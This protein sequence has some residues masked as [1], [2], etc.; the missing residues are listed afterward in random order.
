M[1]PAL[2]VMLCDDAGERFFGEGPCR[3]LHLIEETGS[4][5]SAAAQM[6]LSYS[7]ALAI[8]KRAEAERDGAASA[9]S[10]AGTVRAQRAVRMGQWTSPA[11]NDGAFATQML[12]RLNRSG[13]RGR[14]NRQASSSLPPSQTENR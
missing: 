14:R 13:R 3:L 11:A 7:K 9:G 5:R 12:E 10:V 2:R 1:K 6:G 8:V 4:L